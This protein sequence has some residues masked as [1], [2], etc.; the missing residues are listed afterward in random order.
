MGMEVE[1]DRDPRVVGTGR[2]RRTGGYDF[3]QELPSCVT[4]GLLRNP[5]RS[6]MSQQ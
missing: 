6:H 1:G 3:E 5:R 4:P 2:F